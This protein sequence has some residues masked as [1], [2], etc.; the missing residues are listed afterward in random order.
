[1]L[2]SLNKNGVLSQEQ[3]QSSYLKP[4]ESI[5]KVVRKKLKVAKVL[6]LDSDEEVIDPQDCFQSAL[7]YK[8]QC[9][10]LAA[11]I[12]D[13]EEKAAKDIESLRNQSHHDL[14]KLADESAIH[15]Q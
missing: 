6:L 2:I 8:S 10:Q 14:S 1:M 12:K 13:I 4:L 5:Y 7:S 9:E 11:H 3:I 15:A